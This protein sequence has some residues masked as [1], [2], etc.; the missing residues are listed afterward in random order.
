M[1]W[2][3]GRRSTS[4]TPTATAPR[5]RPSPPGTRDTPTSPSRTSPF[6]QLQQ[7]Q[8]LSARRRNRKLQKFRNTLAAPRNRLVR[9][10]KGGTTSPSPRMW[11]GR[12]DWRRTLENADAWKVSMSPSTDC[13]KWCPLP[14]PTLSCPSTRH[15][16][17]PRR[18]SR[19]CRIFWTVQI[20]PADDVLG[21]VLHV[22]NSPT[23]CD[24]NTVFCESV[25]YLIVTRMSTL[26]FMILI[27]CLS[28]L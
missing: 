16:K 23:E 2:G 10:E 6:L 9:R 19:R 7:P 14:A 13:E 22:S 20:T 8:T 21:H 26:L 18:T 11:R 15:C 5:T 12:E 1:T 3:Q 24:S 17:W 28:T 4:H 25:I 27:Q